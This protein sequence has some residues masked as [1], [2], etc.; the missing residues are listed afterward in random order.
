MPK[1]RISYHTISPLC[2]WSCVVASRDQ[3]K[4]SAPVSSSAMTAAQYD[5]LARL[6][7]MESRRLRITAES[8]TRMTAPEWLTW[9]AG[10]ETML[11]E[12]SEECRARIS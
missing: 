2:N 3:V 10:V 5:F 4:E 8:D 1:K 12:Y 7:Q 6:A 11:R 9:C